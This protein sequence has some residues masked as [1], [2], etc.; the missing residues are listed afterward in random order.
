[1]NLECLWKTWLL[2]SFQKPMEGLAFSNTASPSVHFF[3]Q[4]THLKM[5][6]CTQ[7]HPSSLL[8]LCLQKDSIYFITC[9]GLHPVTRTTPDHLV[10]ESTV[11]NELYRQTAKTARSIA[12]KYSLK[13]LKQLLFDT[14]F[15]DGLIKPLLQSYGWQ[16]WGSE[17]DHLIQGTKRSL[18]NSED[19][20]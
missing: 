18:Q 13:E 20:E 7:T 6:G 14:Q 8:D 11:V 5:A 15:R 3:C 4:C 9:L 1:M 2:A 12:E 19:K 10:F 16:I 17:G